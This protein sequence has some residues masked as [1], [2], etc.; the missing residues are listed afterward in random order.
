[1]QL[2]SQNCNRTAITRHKITKLLFSEMH[3]TF[4]FSRWCVMF[5]QNHVF[6][7]GV[8][9]KKCSPPDQQ[10]I[11]YCL[12]L[13]PPLTGWL[14]EAAKKMTIF[15][16]NCQNFAAFWRLS[17]KFSGFVFYSPP[18]PPSERRNLFPCQKTTPPHPTPPTQI[19]L[20]LLPVANSTPTYDP[21]ISYP[22]PFFDD[23]TALAK[24][25]STMWHLVNYSPMCLFDDVSGV[26]FD[27]VTHSLE[28]YPSFL[29]NMIL[30]SFSLGLEDKSGLL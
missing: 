5:L 9:P 28:V 29:F 7:M 17:R 23:V 24:K 14:L 11:Y 22:T 10:F 26:A 13:F 20:I 30:V 2:R 1:M 6:K 3:G 12:L 4:L 8:R 21:R 15:V 25:K 27:D 16:Q 18:F 19:W